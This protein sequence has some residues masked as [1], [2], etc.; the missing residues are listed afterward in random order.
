MFIYT[1]CYGFLINIINMPFDKG[2]NIQGSKYAY[3]NLK[4]E[5]DFI[6]IN[7]VINIKDCDNNYYRNIFND[8][9]MGC[10]NTHNE[11]KF[12]LL[13]GGDH[14]CVI[15]SIFAS[16]EFCLMKKDKLGILWFDAHADFNT[17]ETSPSGNIH[18]VPVSVLCGHTLPY[19]SYGQFLDTQQF[20]YY[21]VRDIDSLEF[22]R[23]QDYNMKSIDYNGAIDYQIFELQKWMSYF[24]KIHIS[25]DMDCLDPADFSGINTP[26]KNGPKYEYIMSI[27]QEIKKTKKLISMDL[28]EYNPT[29]NNNNSAVL[30]VLKQIF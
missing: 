17:M 13:I 7:K 29:I 12:P 10:W 5:L 15:S 26:V 20:L 11:E 22:E 19:L 4:N 24:D 30:D 1:L 9:F 16:N 8:A 28:V 25:F 6:K 23:F 2:A 14:S 27:L 21:G 3:N 18:G